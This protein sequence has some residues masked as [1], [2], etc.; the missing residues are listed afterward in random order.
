M[1]QDTLPNPSWWVLALR[2]LFALLFG[3]LALAWPAITLLVLVALF[4]AY[5][6][7]AGAAAVIGAVKR[8]GT[9]GWVL[10]LVLGLVSLVAGVLAMF[11]PGP[12]TLALVLVMGV[13]ALVTGAL[14]VALAIRLR[15][16]IPGEWLLA[17]SGVVS[18]V[19]GAVV[20]V[21]PAAGAVALVWLVSFYATLTGVLLL[22]L[23]WRE[24]RWS[25][26]H[27][28]PPAVSRAA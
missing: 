12:T 13:N 20:L 16:V 4:A 10:T 25:A 8:R 9:A 18:I 17:V 22:V 24:R 19:F 6:L 11:Y 5:A 7:L 2:G 21:L 14:D 26:G 27:A 28:A 3:V 23:A 1:N 15:K